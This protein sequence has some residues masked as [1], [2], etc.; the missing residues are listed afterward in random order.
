ML[1]SRATEGQYSDLQTL[2]VHASVGFVVPENEVNL[3]T[4]KMKMMTLMMLLTIMV[5]AI[6][7]LMIMPAKNQCPMT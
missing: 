2:V 5:M 1:H 6:M 3:V 4:M 7:L